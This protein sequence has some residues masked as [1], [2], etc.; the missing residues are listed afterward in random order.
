MIEVGGV[1]EVVVGV[2]KISHRS[3]DLLPYQS[4]T[5]HIKT[6]VSGD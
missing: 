6:K 2:P 4:T 1:V 5:F 3:G